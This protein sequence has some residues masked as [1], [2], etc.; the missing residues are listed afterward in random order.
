MGA[1]AGA[2]RGVLFLRPR[3]YVPPRPARR[4][5]SPLGSRRARRVSPI[6]HGTPRIPGDNKGRRG[7][8]GGVRS[9]VARR[10]LASFHAVFARGEKLSFIII[11]LCLASPAA[12]ARH[13]R[14]ERCVSCAQ[15]ASRDIAI[16]TRYGKYSRMSPNYLRSIARRRMTYSPTVPRVADCST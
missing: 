11:V 8:P 4:R 13:E 5:V 1:R 7:R 2:A 9:S 16:L 6:F 12:A 15:S 3:S 14:H 10:E